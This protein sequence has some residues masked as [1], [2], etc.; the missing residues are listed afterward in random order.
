MQ[1]LQNILNLLSSNV[2][3]TKFRD[4]YHIV[5]SVRKQINLALSLNLSRI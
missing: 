1:L 5:F 4:I 3:F 2:N